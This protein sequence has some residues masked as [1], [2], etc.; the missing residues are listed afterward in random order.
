MHQTATSVNTVRLDKALALLR[1]LSGDG[2]TA[3]DLGG[4]ICVDHS[5]VSRWLA[6]TR[7]PTG[8]NRALLLAWY[9][10][11]VADVRE[12]PAEVLIEAVRKTGE[13]LASL[14]EVKGAADAVLRLI[15][16]L[17][18][19]QQAVCDSLAPWSRAEGIVRAQSA[20]SAQVPLVD[21]PNIV[22]SVKRDAARVATTPTA[23]GKSKASAG[24]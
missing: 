15:H 17:A 3:R 12:P 22:E 5:T 18:E 10:R 23:S 9:D 2:K 16:A 19:Q 8:K 21:L 4:D 24:Q 6:G 11:T 20:L 13:T 7:T 1:S 14:S